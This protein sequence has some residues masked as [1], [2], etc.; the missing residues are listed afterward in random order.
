M[1]SKT[2]FQ[3]PS[4]TFYTPKNVNR[5]ILDPTTWRPSSVAPGV[6]AAQIETVRKANKAVNA[7]LTEHGIKQRV[8]ESPYAYTSSQTAETAAK[9]SKPKISV[10][11]D[12]VFS[13]ADS[14]IAVRKACAGT[15]NVP[16]REQ[17]RIN[18]ETQL[19]INSKRLED[20]F[21]KAA[22]VQADPILQ[23]CLSQK[24]LSAQN[25]PTDVAP[26]PTPKR[27]KVSTTQAHEP[28]PAFY[29]FA[30]WSARFSQAL[31]SLFSKISSLFSSCVSSTDQPHRPNM[32]R[33]YTILR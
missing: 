8:D 22:E 10:S 4:V 14:S 5:G 29:S 18:A 32:D 25:Q 16:E 19:I 13:G 17:A 21:S 7:F 23:I 15:S 31:N 26:A 2:E 3:R 12:K 9:T 1:S 20:E 27:G 28:A 6:W 24:C 11:D 33:I 30:A